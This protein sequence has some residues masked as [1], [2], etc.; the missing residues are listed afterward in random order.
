MRGLMILE[1]ER[2]VCL[3]KFIIWIFTYLSRLHAP[4]RCGPETKLCKY[5]NQS[6]LAHTNKVVVIGKR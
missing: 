1:G 5:F 4:C 6:S 3:N 2:V